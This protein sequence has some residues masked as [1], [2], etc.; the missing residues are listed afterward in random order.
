MAMVQGSPQAQRD[1]SFAVVSAVIFG[2]H[3]DLASH[4]VPDLDCGPDT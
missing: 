1:K 3:Q 2:C 4:A